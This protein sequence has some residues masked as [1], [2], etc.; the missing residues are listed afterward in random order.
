MGVQVLSPESHNSKLR[1][2]PK[3]PK[4]SHYSMKPFNNVKP[5]RA[6]PTVPN[7][8]VSKMDSNIKVARALPRVPKQT[9]NKK[10]LHL[11]SRTGRTLP[12][13]PFRD[14]KDSNTS[15][16]SSRSSTP[17]HGLNT[18]N[19]TQ[20]TTSLHNAVLQNNTLLHNINNTTQLHHTKSHLNHTTH[21]HQNN[22]HEQHGHHTTHHH[23]QNNTHEQHGHQNNT[24]EHNG[25]V[26]SHQHGNTTQ[27]TLPKLPKLS[28]KQ[29]PEQNRIEY[30]HEVYK[31]EGD[32]F[33]EDGNYEQALKSY[34]LVSFLKFP[35][36]CR[37]V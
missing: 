14:L 6:L 30:M 16:G 18:S 24:H 19:S 25:T 26:T 33:S 32:I 28:Q 23:H 9:D 27:R 1:S 22:T 17:R 3:I 12:E 7:S 29:K 10:A 4:N 35:F 20:H 21:H 2:L 15:R 36:L 13:V 11:T 5:S 8:N 37:C 34:N 31:K